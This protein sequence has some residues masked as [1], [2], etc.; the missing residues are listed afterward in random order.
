MS[1]LSREEI[2]RLLKDNI[3]DSAVIAF[4]KIE[5]NLS[6][7]LERSFMLSDKAKADIRKLLYKLKVKWYE[8]KRTE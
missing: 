3:K 2:F 1:G 8:V 5:K 6:E 4:E 7:K